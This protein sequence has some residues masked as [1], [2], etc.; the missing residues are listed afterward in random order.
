VTVPDDY[1]DLTQPDIDLDKVRIVEAGF[2]CSITDDSGKCYS[3]FILARSPEGNAVT[4]CD[5]SFH[6]SGKDR[7]Y[8]PRPT[9]RRTNQKLEDK[10][11]RSGQPYQRIT[12]EGGQDG[13]REFWRMIAFLFKF[14]E[15][16]DIGEFTERYRV[17]SDESVVM[18]LKKKDPEERKVMLAQYA[19]QADI[20]AS[21]L[22]EVLTLRAR[23]DDLEVFRKLLVN[24]DD[25]RAVYRITYAGEIKGSG[26]EAIWHH[27]LSN[28]KW[29][30]GLSLDLRFIEDFVDEASVGMGDTTNRGNPKA[31]MLAWSDYTV[32]VELKTPDADIFT[33][34]KS[35][36]ARAN[37][38]SFSAAFVEGFSQ[39]LGQRSDWEENHKSKIVIVEDEYGRRKELDKG[40]I[41]TIDPQVIFVMWNKAREIP[42]KSPYE[43]IRMKRDTL[44]RFIRNNRN[45]NIISFDELYIRAYHIVYE[46]SPPDGSTV[47]SEKHDTI[48]DD[49][50]PADAASVPPAF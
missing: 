50:D 19:E 26:D 40:I 8:A 48:L 17:V 2:D 45:V 33:A 46:Q 16:V 18:H 4:L 11:V 24:E 22:S 34:V 7:K 41:R 39:C 9:F 6:W 30:F 27:F 32:L 37:T 25:F 28:H 42:R 10:P 38:W 49:L 3:G 47:P 20:S 36:D 31:D 35:K 15:L 13:Y 43:D 21:E 23:K 1:L 29:I 44:E 12:F 14:K 5:L